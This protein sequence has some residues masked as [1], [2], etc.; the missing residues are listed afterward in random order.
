MDIISRINGTSNKRENE[1]DEKFKKLMKL[2]QELKSETDIYMKRVI[3][4]EALSLTKEIK[5]SYNSI[6][7]DRDLMS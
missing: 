6:N 2:I 4:K 3:E 7:V 1:M 5:E